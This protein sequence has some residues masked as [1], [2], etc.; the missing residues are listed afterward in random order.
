MYS[1]VASGVFMVAIV[2][3]VRLMARR[4]LMVALVGLLV[5]LAA[6]FLLA[7][8]GLA[9]VPQAYL[10]V[11]GVEVAI[12]LWA[13][14]S[15]AERRRRW[16]RMAK[17]VKAHSLGVP[18]HG[19]WRVVAGG[20]NPLHN[21][22]LVARDQ[23][24]AYDF[25]RLDGPSFGSTILAPV[26]GEVVSVENDMPDRRPSRKPDDPSVRGR[27]LGNHVGIR[28]AFGTVFLCHLARGSVVV[29]VGEYV[30]SG[31]TVGACGNS[32]R[33]T[34][35]HLHLHA[36]DVP[37]YGFDSAQ[38]LPIAFPIRGDVRVLHYGDVIGEPMDSAG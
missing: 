21:H 3:V 17:G 29:N 24:F 23:V 8:A 33:T 4:S 27:E 37:V 15:G 7:A 19:E 34:M 35:P 30:A 1:F 12:G 10:P 16:H 5:C 36:Q 25:V 32:G 31:T 9:P 28:A 26:D 22:H 14:A 20:A 18:F 6:N 2:A 11:V 13:L 38:G